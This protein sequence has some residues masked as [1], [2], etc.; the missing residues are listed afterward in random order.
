MYNTERRP[1]MA[2][3][4]PSIIASSAQYSSSSLVVPHLAGIEDPLPD[5]TPDKVDV[6][7]AGTGMV[8]SVLAAALA[9]QGSSV[10]HIDQNDYYGDTSATL[11]V[12]QLKRWVSQINET[13]LPCY[14]NAK[15][16]VSN[17][18]GNDNRKYISRDFGIDLSPKFLFAKSDLLSILVKSRVHQY[19]E[20]QSLSTFHTYEND[21]FEKLTNTKQEIFTNQN[22]P[23]MTKRNLM[24][25]I[26][27]VLDWEKHPQ[28]WEPYATKSITE[29]LIEKF[30]LE[31]AQVNE[32]IFSIGLC[33]T[34]DTKVPHALQRIRRYLIS[35]DVY[36]PFP[37]LYSKF[38][39]P[40]ELSQGFCRSAAVAGATYKLN[41]KLQSFDPTT[42]VATFTDGSKVMV[43]EKVIMS[44]TQAPRSHK[45][46]PKQNFEIHRLT[47]VVE[48]S[49]SEWFTNNESGAVIVFPP[50]SLKSGNKRVVQ[51]LIL[52]SGSECCP[53]GTCIWYL[54]TTEQGDRAEMDLDAALEA[55]EISIIRESS[56]DIVNDE[57]IVQITDNGQTVVNSVKLGQS[58]REYYPREP[59]QHLLK[60]YYTQHT[61]TPPFDIVAPS[62]FENETT[63]RA[64][65][66]NKF[67]AEAGD[68]GVMY[69]AMPST[70]ISYDEVVTAAKLLY[71]KIVGSDDDFF[72]VDFEDE[73]E[74]MSNPP[75]AKYENAIIDDED[76]D[77]DMDADSSEFVGEMEI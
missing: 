13:M 37:V 62:L 71:E 7:I 48:K 69:T 26:K 56:T 70:E 1:S 16:Y 32:L 4:R 17:A 49:C 2:E 27:F 8:E 18:I 21:S 29:F 33:Y 38:G 74:M 46:V 28:I 35:F 5:T 75:P 60:L 57:D 64:N 47:C 54:S 34:A 12:D 9:W 24:R 72:D 10:L 53:S 36:G 14:S 58:F 31:P 43:S 15:L 41:E 19:L 67:T 22:L 23:L 77:H 76:A 40:G 50:G 45:H 11:T 68:N 25:F 42:K 73:E 6:L 3:R 30:N 61:S 55:M 63:I 66:L 39:G 20:F 52:G 59:V 51:A 44:P 65:K